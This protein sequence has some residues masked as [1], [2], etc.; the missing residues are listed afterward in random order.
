MDAVDPDVDVVP[1]LEGPG[2]EVLA[3]LLPR[4]GQAGDGGRRQT[5]VG[6]EELSERRGEV[7]RGEPVQIEQRQHLA[8]LGGPAYVR[9]QDLAA[10]AQLLAAAVIDPA[11]VN[12]RGPEGRQIEGQGP[13]L[14][15]RGVCLTPGVF[16]ALS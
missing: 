10:E 16:P 14:G 8:D 7:T 1:V 6:A 3:L 5:G 9:R 2:H 4:R 15:A 13:Q 12:P 11:V